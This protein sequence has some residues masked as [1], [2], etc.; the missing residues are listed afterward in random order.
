M[1]AQGEIVFLRSLHELARGDKVIFVHVDQSEDFSQVLDKLSESDFF[2]YFDRILEFLSRLIPSIFGNMQLADIL[3]RIGFN[4]AI[5]EVACNGERF[6]APP[7]GFVKFAEVPTI[8]AQVIEIESLAFS[9]A[10]FAVDKQSFLVIVDGPRN[11][12]DFRI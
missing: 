8:Q 12:T 3:V 6:R 4:Q 5:A 9:I 10:Y 7:Q 1:V 2:G 11:L